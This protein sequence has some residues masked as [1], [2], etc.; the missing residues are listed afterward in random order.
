MRAFKGDIFILLASLVIIIA[1]LKLA[2]KVFIT[3]FL[4]IILAS[5]LSPVLS[6]LQRLKVPKILAL[7]VI[8]V[9]VFIVLIL[10]FSILSSSTSEFIR[11]LPD[12]QTKLIGLSQEIDNFFIK[13]DL[14]LDVKS[15]IEGLN[16]SSLFSVTTKTA[17]KIGNFLSSLI[18][19]I[20]GTF[21]LLAESESFNTKIKK[22]FAN[23]KNAIVAI[24]YF[25][26][27]VKKYFFIK[28][29]TSFLTGILIALMLYFFK[30]KYFIL[31]K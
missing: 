17:F 14:N 24:D 11:Y 30:I 9:L 16:F 18:L 12:Y 4:S 19:V 3:I 1:A 22:L 10:F 5:L 13:Y 7:I 27:T 2:S 15:I 21:F 25:L 31:K 28:V 26:V 20:I 23:N 8:L 6:F 29:F